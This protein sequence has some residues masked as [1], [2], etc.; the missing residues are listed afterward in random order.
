MIVPS[1][2]G[3]WLFWDRG[4]SELRATPRCVL[5][6]NH[7]EAFNFNLKLQNELPVNGLFPHTKALRDIEKN[8]IRTPS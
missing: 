6:D 3:G 1:G 4:F 5:N 7:D 8:T 2:A